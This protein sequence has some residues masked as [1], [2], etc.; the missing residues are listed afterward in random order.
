MRRKRTLAARY[1]PEARND[2]R[3]NMSLIA[4]EEHFAWDPASAGNVVATWLRSNNPV[5]YQRHQELWTA[6]VSISS[7]LPTPPS[8]GLPRLRTFVPPGVTA[9]SLGELEPIWSFRAKRT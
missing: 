7:T 8:N 6:A 4:L 3:D 9:T 2:Y 5:A 1:G